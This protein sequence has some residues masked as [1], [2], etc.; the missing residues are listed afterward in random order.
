MSNAIG[1]YLPYLCLFD[2]YMLFEWPHEEQGIKN[3]LVNPCL[4]SSVTF[5]KANGLRIS[6]CTINNLIFEICNLE[7]SKHKNCITVLILNHPA[8]LE[9]VK[10]LYIISYD[11]IFF[12]WGVYWCFYDHKFTH[13]KAISPSESVLLSFICLK[14]RQFYSSKG[15]RAN[16]LS[17]FTSFCEPISCRILSLGSKIL[18]CYSSKT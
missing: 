17:T 11:M 2:V 13:Q 12:F 15:D 10:I 8:R 5:V 3:I 1:L 16:W 9:F 4:D 18:W 7:T 6:V 14:G